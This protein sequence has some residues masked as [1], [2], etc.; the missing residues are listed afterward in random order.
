MRFVIIASLITSFGFGCATPS[1]SAQPKSTH[2][3]PPQTVT[4]NGDK[5]DVIDPLILSG[6]FCKNGYGK[7]LNQEYAYQGTTLDGRPYYRGAARDDRY[8]Y[9]DA[10][11]SDDS[12]EPRWILG[13]KP[14]ITLKSDL[15]R[16]D[17]PG[18]DNDLGSVSDAA[19]PEVG[20]HK[21][22]WHWCGDQG[23]RDRSITISTR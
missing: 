23:Y 4:R 20:T 7:S 8:L 1:P 6:F 21:V 18:C 16:Y 5:A 15:N 10:R 11:C 3:T 13:G 9:F 14:D 22:S 2:A 12:P 19:A 17:N